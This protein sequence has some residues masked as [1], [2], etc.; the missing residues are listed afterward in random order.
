MNKIKMR[1][2][3]K[4]SILTCITLASLSTPSTILADSHPGYSYESNIG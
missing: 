4:I 1:N 3:F 2:F